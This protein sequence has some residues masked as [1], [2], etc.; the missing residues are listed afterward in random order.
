MDKIKSQE[1][2]DELKKVH[3]IKVIELTK[4][5]ERLIQWEQTRPE[6]IAITRQMLQ[7]GWDIN[8]ETGEIYP[9]EENSILAIGKF[10]KDINK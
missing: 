5:E 6:A 7:R 1:E 2:Y 3:E 10:L 9:T 4:L 8:E